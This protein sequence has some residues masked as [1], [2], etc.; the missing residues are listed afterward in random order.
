MGNK[1]VGVNLKYNV[2]LIMCALLLK[3]IRAKF[4]KFQLGFCVSS[5]NE[6][7]IRDISSS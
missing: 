4:T 1:K 5:K 7:K 3:M 6:F 2:T